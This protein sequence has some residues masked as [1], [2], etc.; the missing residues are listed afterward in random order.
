MGAWYRVIKKINGRRYAYLQ[1]TWREGKHVCTE[2]EYLGPVDGSPGPKEPRVREGKVVWHDI[3]RIAFHGAREGIIEGPIRPS[4]EGTFGPGFYLTSRKRAGD[5]ARYEAK[6]AARLPE[7]DPP[8]PEPLYDGIV[9]SCDLSDLKLRVLDDHMAYF[10]LVDELLQVDKG[11]ATPE[12]KE[13][14]QEIL[15]QKGYDGLDIRDD[16]RKEVIIF[17]TSLHKIKLGRT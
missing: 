3:R 6:W 8:L 7:L 9:Y 2:N 13:R 11:Y 14:V 10:D 4:P 1:R 12:D 5:Y 17:P 16:I 15:I